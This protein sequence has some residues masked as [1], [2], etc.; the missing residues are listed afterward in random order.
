[1][2]LWRV[3][4]VREGRRLVVRE[5]VSESWNTEYS[6]TGWC[7]GCRYYKNEN[8][9]NSIGRLIKSIREVTCSKYP[10]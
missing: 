9:S 1:M 10:R 3:L 7:T 8:E 4:T 2:P 6:R 5:S